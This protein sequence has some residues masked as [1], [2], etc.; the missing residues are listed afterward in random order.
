[1]TWPRS[2]RQRCAETRATMPSSTAS[3]S[4]GKPTGVR[5]LIAV[6]YADMVGYSRLIGA[7]D[8]R[9]LARLQALRGSVFDPAISEHGGSVVQTGGDS[10]LVVFDS[11]EGA[12][13]CAVTVQQQV[14]DHDAGH[15]P[16]S[17]IR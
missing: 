8:V 7:D 1:M 6:M 16:D 2:A 10:L 17:A 12:V 5:K 15:D 14:P 9:T 11:I 3:G 13:R 4:I